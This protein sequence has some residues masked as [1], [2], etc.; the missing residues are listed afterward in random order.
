MTRQ[1]WLHHFMG[2]LSQPLF[3]HKSIFLLCL[4]YWIVVLNGLL[5]H[6]FSK[7]LIKSRANS[8]EPTRCLGSVFLPS[9][10]F[11]TLWSDGLR[12]L[13]LLVVCGPP[14]RRSRIVQPKCLDRP[15][16][17]GQVTMIGCPI[18]IAPLMPPVFLLFGAFQVTTLCDMFRV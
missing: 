8:A 13:L 14:S 18:M 7:Q 17:V 1:S 11:T 4:F 5:L 16:Y 10:C 2:R 15:T 9:I 12:S 3:S 6:I